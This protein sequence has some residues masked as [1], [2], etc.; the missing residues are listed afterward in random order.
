ALLFL[1]DDRFNNEV[2]VL[3]GIEN[4]F[5]L[6]LLFDFSGLAFHLE[7]AGFELRRL[8][9]FELGD[10]GPVLFRLARLNLF[11]TFDDQSKRDG[12]NTAGRNTAT[13]LVPQERADLISDK[14]I[15][16]PASLLS[17]NDV[18]IDAARIF[19]GGANRLRGDFVEQDPKNFRFVAVEDF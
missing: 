6:L 18:L 3:H 10:D 12:L 5:G 19:D 16:N 8:V 17:V 2:R 9:T 13:D 11:F 7:E 4:V 1:G 14:A 15:K